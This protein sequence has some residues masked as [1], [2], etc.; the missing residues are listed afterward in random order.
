MSSEQLLQEFM[1]YF[2]KGDI[3]AMVEAHA[4]HAVFITPMGIMAGR[5]R[6]RGMIEAVLSEFS[7]PGMTFEVTHQS[8]S[9]PAALLVWKAQTAD[10]VYDFAAETFVFGD[11]GRIAQH[12]FAAKVIPRN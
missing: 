9:G 1:G 7:K 4:P 2:G 10:N 12:T 11:D 3:D 6:I 8:A 5:D